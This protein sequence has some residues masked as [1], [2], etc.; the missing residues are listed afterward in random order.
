LNKTLSE[1][2]MFWDAIGRI[3]ESN[4]V[5]TMTVLYKDLC[6]KPEVLMPEIFEFIGVPPFADLVVNATKKM[7]TRTLRNT[8]TNHHEVAQLLKGTPYEN[9]L[10]EVDSHCR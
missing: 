6:Q 3:F 1:D 4:G 7:D 2:E 9:Q 8:I 5:E 10:D